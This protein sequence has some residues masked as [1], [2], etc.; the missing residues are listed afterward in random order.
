MP[1]PGPSEALVA[2]DAASINPLDFLLASGTF[3]AMRHEL[4]YAVCRE[5]VGRV[6]HKSRSAASIGSGDS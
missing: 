2:V 5:G 1:E 4:P 6:V 3:Y